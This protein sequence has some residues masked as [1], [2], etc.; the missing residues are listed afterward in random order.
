MPWCNV[1]SC[2]KVFST[3]TFSLKEEERKGRTFYPDDRIKNMEDFEQLATPEEKKHMEMI[4]AEFY[5]LCSRGNFQVMN[6]LILCLF[7]EN[8]ALTSL[9]FNY[10]LTKFRPLFTLSHRG[11]DNSPLLIVFSAN[12]IDQSIITFM[13]LKVC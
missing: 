12:Y 6:V 11:S 10:N 4:K 2:P 3:S 5:Q 8:L 13:P 7:L 9:P 1:Q